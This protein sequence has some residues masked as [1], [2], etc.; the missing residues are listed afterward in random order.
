[1]TTT[2]VNVRKAKFDVYIGRPGPFGNPYKIG[3]RANRE[4]VLVAFSVYF[5]RRVNREQWFR[6]EVEKL[7]GKVLGCYCAGDAPLTAKDPHVCHGQIIAEW[8]DDE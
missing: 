1:V 3:K 4:E 5:E 7:K 6:Q 2:I 8:L